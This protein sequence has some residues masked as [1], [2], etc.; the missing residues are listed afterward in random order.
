[1]QVCP[2]NTIKIYNTMKTKIV[3]LLILVLL[4][5]LPVLAQDKEKKE[6]NL[7]NSVSFNNVSGFGGFMM[8]FTEVNNE[9]GVFTGGGGGL[10]INQQFYF[11]G[12]GMGLASEH[13]YASEFDTL[14]NHLDFGHGGFWVGYINKPYKLVH[15]G[16]SS[17]MGWGALSLYEKNNYDNSIAKELVF[18]VSPQAD[19]EV[20]FTKWFKLNTSIG[21]KLV[22]GIDKREIYDEK[23]FNGPYAMISFLFGGFGNR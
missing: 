7:F 17:K 3:S 8:Q 2:G 9:F 4:F 11:G 13:K 15:W 18:V 16:I 23:D 14:R 19:M 10:L 12:Y 20:N 21:Y 6:E 1:M 22:A 5:S